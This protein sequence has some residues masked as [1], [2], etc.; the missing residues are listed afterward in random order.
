MNASWEEVGKSSA[1]LMGNKT[2]QNKTSG[3][4]RDGARH[5]WR[6]HGCS[7]IVLL[8]LLNSSCLFSDHLHLSLQPLSLQEVCFSWLML[9]ILLPAIART[10]M[11]PPRSLFISLL[12][13]I[14]VTAG[15]GRRVATLSSR[16]CCCRG[17]VFL[18][19]LFIYLFIA[20]VVEETAVSRSTHQAV[21]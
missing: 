13:L 19:F 11:S 12:V 18:I 10:S 21:I 1:S 17:G 14:M 9:F 8:F 2:K 16:R 3:P 5:R 4:F 15:R 20:A 6:N 7:T